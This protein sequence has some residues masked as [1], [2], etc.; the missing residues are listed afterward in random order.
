M[1]LMLYCVPAVLLMAIVIFFTS[2]DTGNRVITKVCGGNTIQEQVREDN[3]I[4]DNYDLRDQP[5]HSQRS[6]YA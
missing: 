1:K 6:S 5:S 4:E 3:E 2:C